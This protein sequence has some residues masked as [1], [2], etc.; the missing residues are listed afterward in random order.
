MPEPSLHSS[1]AFG[2]SARGLWLLA[3]VVVTARL[4]FWAL[5][6]LTIE[7]SLIS[8]RYAE[9]LASGLGLVYNP[10]ERVFGASTP[11]YVLFLALLTKL[12]LPALPIAKSLAILADG[13]TMLLWG[14]WL[15]RETGSR[16]SAVVFALLF[17]LSPLIVPVSISGM[18]T[19][20]ALL[21]LTV[22]LLQAMRTPEQEQ[23]GAPEWLA[24]GLPLGLLVLVRPDGGIAAA[25]LLALRWWRTRRLPWAAG[26]TAALVVLPWIVTAV[27]YYGTP[28]PHSIPAKAAAYNLHRPSLWPNFWGTL[29]ELAPVSGPWWKV[30]LSALICPLWLAGW[31]AAA[32]DARLRPLA[33][34]LPVW[35]AYLVFPKTLLFT[36]YFPLL[37]LPAYVLAAFGYGVLRE[38]KQYRR[39]L[40]PRGGAVAVSLVGV[41]VAGTLVHGIFTWSRVQRAERSVRTAIGLWLKEN[42]P[43]TA[44]IAMEPIGYIGYYSRRRILDEVGLVSPEMVPL[45]R[46]GAGWFTAMLTQFKPDYVVERPGYLLRNRTLNSGVPLFAELNERDAFLAQYEPVTAFG[47]PSAPRAQ[48]YRFV[49][50]K[51]RSAGSAGQWTRVFEELTE[52]ERRELRT[53][54][55]IGP[56]DWRALTVSRSGVRSLASAGG[57]GK[58]I[59]TG[60]PAPDKSGAAPLQP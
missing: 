6:G 39:R 58:R 49:I 57:T 47:D 59:R 1:R 9:N 56:Y 23:K 33:V 52:E 27:I 11:I 36:W 43:E 38:G 21:L 15:L 8:L 46:E 22:A 7:D 20:F 4:L 37:V 29:K 14:G 16:T 35:W 31:W 41:V 10:G 30:L 28:V 60:L 42:T 17:G 53:R 3:G 13:A 50:F 2:G 44:R 51:R 40:S 5:T 54:S 32:R 19:S 12:G 24:L 18:E 34:L 26:V 45:N 55:L 25:V 48:D